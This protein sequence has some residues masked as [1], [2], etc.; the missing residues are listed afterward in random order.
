M[1]KPVSAHYQT[2]GLWSLSRDYQCLVFIH[3][4]QMWFWMDLVRDA[5]LHDSRKSLMA[6][7]QLFRI[8]PPNLL[9]LI[10]WTLCPRDFNPSYSEV[11]WVNGHLMALCSQPYCHWFCVICQYCGIFS[12][13]SVSLSGKMVLVLSTSRTTVK[14]KWYKKCYVLEQCASNIKEWWILIIASML[15]PFSHTGTFWK[16]S[17]LKSISINLKYCWPFSFKYLYFLKP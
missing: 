11:V 2:G 12:W 1:Y 6:V 8:L 5:F 4:N 7:D 9:L 10:L 17:L 3:F 13:V 16:I 14:N 15:P